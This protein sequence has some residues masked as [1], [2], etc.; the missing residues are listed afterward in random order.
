MVLLFAAGCGGAGAACGSTGTDLASEHPYR[1]DPSAAG[2]RLGVPDPAC[3]R[4]LR[5]RIARLAGVEGSGVSGGRARVGRLLAK[6][7]GGV[8]PRRSATHGELRADRGLGLGRTSPAAVPPIPPAHRKRVQH[9]RPQPSQRCGHVAVH[10]GDRD[11]VRYGSRRI[12]RRAS[13]PVQVDRGCGRLPR[14]PARRIR[15]VVL[16]AC[17]L[18]RRPQPGTSNSESVRGRRAA[19]RQP[20]LGTT[21]AL[22]A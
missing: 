10:G 9:G 14:G 22:A 12:R 17:R 2:G 16:G 5:R 8:V 21:G 20:V 1:S 6:R 7:G 13:P 18:Q 3:G 15:F 11:R 19:F 4:A